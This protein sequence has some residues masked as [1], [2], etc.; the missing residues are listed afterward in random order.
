MND[1]TNNYPNNE[2]AMNPQ[3]EAFNSFIQSAYENHV[4]NEL[5]ERA[6][7]NQE[8]IIKNQAAQEKQHKAVNKDSRNTPFFILKTPPTA[9]RISFSSNVGN[10]SRPIR[11]S[12]NN[13]NADRLRGIR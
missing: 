9:S 12:T 13:G 8:K 3:D 6:I 7:A 10:V 1:Y 4:T 5:L 2:P 11:L